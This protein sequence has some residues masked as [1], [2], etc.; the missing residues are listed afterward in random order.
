MCVVLW[1]SPYTPAVPHKHTGVTERSVQGNKVKAN[2][3]T[4]IYELKYYDNIQILTTRL[5]FFF[6]SQRWKGQRIEATQ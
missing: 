1:L 5:A 3:T 4:Y 6:F 2:N